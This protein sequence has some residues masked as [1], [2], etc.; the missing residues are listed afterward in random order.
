MIRLVPLVVLLAFTVSCRPSDTSSNV[1]DKFDDATL[2]DVWTKKKFLPGSVEMQSD[3]VRNGARAARIR[4]RPGDQIEQEKGTLLER[5][6]ITE[7]PEYWSVED[8]LY[9]Y[10]F[11]L[12]LP[13]DFPT[14]STRLVIA[15]WKQECDIESC[16]PDNPILA[17]RYVAKTLS[18]TLKGPDLK[19][20][21]ETSENV[22]G[23]WLDFRF[24]VSFSRSENG[25]IEAWMNNS[26][27]AEYHGA[28]AYKN[29]G[30][31]PDKNLFY[32]KAGLYRDRMESVMTIYIDEYSKKLVSRGVR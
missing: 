32:F 9:S 21:Y 15:Q 7:A 1:T 29:T 25:L 10:T 6:E 24:D 3:I 4:L 28:N 17:V 12:Y 11:S 13:E 14:D 22:L 31:Y 20:I 27:V 16:T 26:K 23:R 2:S 8:S 30:G 19:T 18:I 5:A